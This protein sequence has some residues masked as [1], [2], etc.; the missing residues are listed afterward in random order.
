MSPGQQAV[1]KRLAEWIRKHEH[2]MEVERE[3]WA[4]LRA[5]KAS[6]YP[7]LTALREAYQHIIVTVYS[8][9]G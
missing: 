5:L 7:T 4:S 6:D 9:M 8:E 1:E 3:I 2:S